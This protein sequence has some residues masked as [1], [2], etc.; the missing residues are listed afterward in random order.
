MLTRLKVSGFKNLVDTELRFG[1][2]TWIAGY[3]GVGK[4]NIFD[5]IRFLSLLAD[6]SFVEAAHGVRGGDDLAKLFTTGGDRT[7]RFECDLLVPGSGYDDFHQPAE[8]THTFLTYVLELALVEERGLLRIELRREQLGYVKQEEL[9]RRFGFKVDAE[10]LKSV[11]RKP[12]RRVTYI[13]TLDDGPKR[14]RLSSDRM[15]EATKSKRGG[16]KPMDFS[17]ASLPRTVLSAA[18]N[19]DEARTAVLARAEMRA[20]RVLQLEPSSLRVPDELQADASL[21]TEGHHLPA[22]LFRLAGR[23]DGERVLAEISNRLAQLVDDVRDVR[24][25][26]LALCPVGRDGPGKGQPYATF[27]PKLR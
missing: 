21:T 25:V 18:Q 8:A 4:S 27:S 17:M 1:P 2:F 24:V 26:K 13:E 6:H 23:P 3:N 12:S 20:W 10:W 19:A 16:G 11:V 7:M 9:A 5:A 22:T 15:R 14:I